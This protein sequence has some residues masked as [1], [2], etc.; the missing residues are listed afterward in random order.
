MFILLP[1]ALY[2]LKLSLSSPTVFASAHTFFTHPLIKLMSLALM[3][4]FLHHACA[5]I[6]FL[7]LDVHKGIDLKTARASAYAV[8]GVSIVLTLILGSLVLL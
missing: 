5:G 3:W 1:F 7:L 4:A 8:F 6:R 2:L